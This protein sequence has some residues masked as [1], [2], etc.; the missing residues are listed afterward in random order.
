MSHPISV[1]SITQKFIWQGEEYILAD[2]TD[3]YI[4]YEKV[5][6]ISGLSE[7]RIGFNTVT[8]KLKVFSPD[9]LVD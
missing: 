7:I 1:L 9:T 8:G 6:C 2:P 3:K 4:D 5:W